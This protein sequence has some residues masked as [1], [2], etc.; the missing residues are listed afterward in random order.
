MAMGLWEAAG[1]PFSYLG[2]E[3]LRGPL[4]APRDYSTLL[5]FARGTSHRK[6]FSHV[7]SVWTVSPESHSARDSI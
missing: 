4:M 3:H 6:C 1:F 2:E 5:S 7:F